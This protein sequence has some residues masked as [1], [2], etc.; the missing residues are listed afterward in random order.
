MNSDRSLPAFLSCSLHGAP[1]V[2]NI[3]A[4]RRKPHYLLAWTEF[5]FLNPSLSNGCRRSGSYSSFR[6][7][8][9][10]RQLSTI[11]P[12]LIDRPQQVCPHAQWRQ[13]RLPGAFVGILLFDSTND[14]P[15]QGW[16]RG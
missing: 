12:R 2:L 13:K 14:I 9:G 11:G 8:E 16:Q 6:Q 7:P 10:R 5:Q 4:A 1:S 3:S 15:K